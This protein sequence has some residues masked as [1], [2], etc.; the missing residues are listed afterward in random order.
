MREALARRVLANE[1]GSNRDPVRKGRQMSTEQAEQKAVQAGSELLSDIEE[2]KDQAARRV[3]SKVR[4]KWPWLVGGVVVLAVAGVVLTK[5][6]RALLRNAIRAA[7]I[8]GAGVAGRRFIR[9][10]LVK[11]LS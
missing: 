11:A 6:G 2:L 9:Q 1:D 7:A 5:P 3:A 8:K 10:T 4:S